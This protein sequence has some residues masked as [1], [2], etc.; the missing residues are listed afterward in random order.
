MPLRT[1]TP[2]KLTKHEK[3][4]ENVSAHCQSG[5][6]DRAQEEG[7]MKQ[8]GSAGS[9]AGRFVTAA[10]C[11]KEGSERERRKAERA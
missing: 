2:V 10:H 3:E 4:M 6:V 1:V 11:L 7:G 9:R 5:E 8:T